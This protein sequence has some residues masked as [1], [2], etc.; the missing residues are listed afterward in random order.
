MLKMNVFKE[1]DDKEAVETDSYLSFK[2]DDEFFAVDVRQVIEILEV[3]SITR[4]PL[5]PAY[6]SGIIN[7]RGK[8][9]PLIDTKVKFGLEPIVKTINTCIIVIELNVEDEVIQI[10]AMVDSVLEVLEI[11]KTQIQPS[12]SIEAKYP[13][14]FIKGMFRKDDDFIML[15]SLDAVFSLEDVQFMQDTNEAERA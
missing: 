2:L 14:D 10:G 12:P 4:V 13:L 7:L 8:V 9:L 5:A 15:V 3:P 6:M 1:K 11:E